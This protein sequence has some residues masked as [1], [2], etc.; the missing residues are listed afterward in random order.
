M[1]KEISPQAAA[2]LIVV[3]A[4]VIIAVGWKL[5]IAETKIPAD[6]MPPAPPIVPSFDRPA[7]PSSP[8]KAPAEGE[9]NSS[10][11]PLSRF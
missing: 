6:Q 4:A 2:V 1:K 11:S 10:L 7:G 9:A 3:I 8:S 5:F